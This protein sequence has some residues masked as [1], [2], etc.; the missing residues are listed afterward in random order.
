MIECLRFEHANVS[1]NSLTI[2]LI[3]YFYIQEPKTESVGDS[4]DS[5]ISNHLV[6]NSNGPNNQPVIS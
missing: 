4:H 1:P 5:S 6:P 2:I 3:S